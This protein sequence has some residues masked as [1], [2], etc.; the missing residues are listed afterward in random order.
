MSRTTRRRA[1][2]AVAPVVG[3]LAAGLLVWQGSYAAFSATTSNTSD[4]WATG[5]LVLNN[6]GGNGSTYAGS[7][8]ALFSLATLKSTDTGTKCITVDSQ[9][10][11]GGVLKFYRGAITDT[12]TANPGSNLSTKLNLVV[13]AAPLL[14]SQSVDSSCAAGT[15]TVAFPTT[16]TTPI[17]SGSLNGLGTSYSGTGMTLN[18]GA[19]ERVAYKIAWSFDTTID[20]TYQSAS[21]QANLV[22]EVQ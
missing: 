22:W 1:I 14:T 13:T 2:R 7:T 9:G 20:N 12:N 15:G 11:I 19:N 10:T 3:L 8:G 17:Y 18:G 16:G 6:N 21:T 4:A 5:K